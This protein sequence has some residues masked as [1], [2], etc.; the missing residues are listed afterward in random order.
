MLSQI[1][2]VLILLV[3]SLYQATGSASSVYAQNPQEIL[4][5][6]QAYYER[7]EYEQAAGL[8]YRLAEEGHPEGM[9]EIAFMLRDGV[10]VPVNN[11]KALEYLEMAAERGFKHSFQPLAEMY[12]KMGMLE[13][14]MLF[15][16]LGVK[17]FPENNKKVAFYY[18]DEE[19]Y[20]DAL[21]FVKRLAKD[22]DPDGVFLN[23]V[24]LYEGFGVN[25][26]QKSGIKLLK[27]AAEL[28]HPAAVN[29][30][31]DIEAE[32]APDNSEDYDTEFED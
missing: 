15:Y 17:D 29:Y 12:E 23:G 30:L 14:A 6:A 26:N 2:S 32:N 18:F 20:E 11:A 22:N 9:L 19:N 4:D 10:G 3:L 21:P 7:Q 13:E 5:S 16:K 8:F 31:K 25:Q 1:K 27:K 24:M 28:G